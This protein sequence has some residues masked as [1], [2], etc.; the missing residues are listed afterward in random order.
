MK[1]NFYTLLCAL[2]LVGTAAMAQNKNLYFVGTTLDVESDKDIQVLNAIADHGGYDV[3]EIAFGTLLDSD[4]PVFNAA[5]IVIMGRSINSG[6][7]GVSKDLWDQVTTPVMSM[8]MWGLRGTDART[9]KGMWVNNA[10]CENIVDDEAAVVEANILVDDAVF[11]GATGTQDWWN[12]R[13]SAFGPDAEGD[14]AGNGVLL[15]ETADNRPLFIR[16]S[17]NVEFYPGAG[18]SPL[19]ERTFIGCGQDN[20]APNVYFGFSDFGYKVFF[21]ELARMAGAPLGVKNVDAQAQLLSVYSTDGLVSVSMTNLNR[22][23]IFTLD[24]KKI[25]S[26]Q[27]TAIGNYQ[28]TLQNGLYIVKAVSNTGLTASKKVLVK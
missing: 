1:R 9:D 28:S 6:D 3:T 27:A 19:G 8:N 12:G 7:V 13:Y 14:D 10:E 22:V 16:W 24:G 20:T 11:E 2:L 15:A 26:G 18:H 23:E 4:I 25:A 17:A 21:N 5:D